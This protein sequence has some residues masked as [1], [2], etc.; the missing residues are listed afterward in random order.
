MPDK[1][2]AYELARIYGISAVAAMRGG[3]Y[4]AKQKRA[5]DKLAERTAKRENRR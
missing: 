3:T 5:L 2:S 4:T 1:P